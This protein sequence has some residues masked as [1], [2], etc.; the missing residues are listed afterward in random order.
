MFPIFFI[1]QTLKSEYL[2]FK[3]QQ[4]KDII[5]SLEEI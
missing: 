1:K 4:K 2:V 5:K 3:D